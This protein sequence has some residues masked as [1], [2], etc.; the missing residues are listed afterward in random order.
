MTETE[1]RLK[2]IPL[3][4]EFVPVLEAEVRKW[5][6]KVLNKKFY[7]A[8]TDLTQ[9][10]YDK[11][12]LEN[13]NWNNTVR[14][15]RD[16]KDWRGY[17]PVDLTVAYEDINYHLIDAYNEEEFAILETGKAPRVNADEVIKNIEMEERERAECL[18][19]IKNTLNHEEELKA[20]YRMIGVLAKKLLSDD[21]SHKTM[22]DTFGFQGSILDDLCSARNIR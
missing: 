9:K 2:M 5:D 7:N 16:G 3:L 6:G 12:N 21:Y 8:L 4:K 14:Y 15:H 20:T 10:W 17:V 22:V 13:D 19:T 1:N 18:D 11:E